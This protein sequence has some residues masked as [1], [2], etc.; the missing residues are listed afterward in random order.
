MFFAKIPR[1]TRQ[2]AITE[3][4]L[5]CI[6]TRNCEGTEQLRYILRKRRNIMTDRK[7]RRTSDRGNRRRSAKVKSRKQRKQN[8]S[9]MIFCIAMEMIVV[10]ILVLVVGWNYGMGTQLVEWIEQM[11]KPVVK[12]L[13]ISGINS[14]YAV[15][16]QVRGGRVIGEINGEQQMYPAS[17]TKIMTTI[18]AIEN[19]KDLDQEITL[20]NEMFEGLYEQDATQAGFQPGETVRAIDLLYGVMLP[21]GAEC[22]IAL[23]DTI[24]GSEADFVT[25][26][27][28]KAA[29]LGM[30]GTNFC[31]TTGLHDANHYSTAKDIAVLLKYAL[32]NDT[33]REIIES[34]YHSTP[35]T[36]IHPDGI[37]FYSTMFKNLSD[38]VVT[39]GQIMGGKTGYTGEAGHC[40]A[41]FAE[42]DGTEYILVTGGASGT[43]IPH[44]NDAL[45]VYN[46]LGAAAQALNEGEIK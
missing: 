29:K 38:T 4:D 3:G 30:S 11:R 17:M 6:L 12:E 13:D 19:L 18:V 34:P 33:F 27:N 35:A 40:L 28:E 39:D 25:L 7:R 44:I 24:S 14:P 22:C 23:A 20:T 43:G 37:T 42:I 9:R 46:R 2:N 41:S 26:M 31:D 5:E 1:H 21:S 8:K 36:N 10:L 15:L 45:T 32:R 16:M